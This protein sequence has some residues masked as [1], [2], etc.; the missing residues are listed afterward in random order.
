[1][2]LPGGRYAVVR[3]NGSL[4]AAGAQVRATRARLQDEFALTVT[5]RPILCEW[6]S[7]AALLL[8]DQF[9]L[10]IYLPVAR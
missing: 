8:P 9:V 6:V 5:D 4:M 10:D 2:T 3:C 7:D 1:M